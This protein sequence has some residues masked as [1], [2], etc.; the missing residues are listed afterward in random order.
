MLASDMAWFA[1]LLERNLGEEG[2]T[3][4]GFQGAS[5]LSQALPYPANFTGGEVGFEV[6]QGEDMVFTERWTDT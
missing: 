4:T 1:Q 5:V 2:V 3:G 6:Q